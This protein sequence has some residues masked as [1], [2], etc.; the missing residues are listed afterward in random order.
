MV[1]KCLCTNYVGLIHGLHVNSH[2]GL[3]Q[4]ISIHHTARLTLSKPPLHK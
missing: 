1:E 3:Y 4:L 2:D